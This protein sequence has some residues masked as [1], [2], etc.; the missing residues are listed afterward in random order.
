[1]GPDGRGANWT[2][3]ARLARQGR[4]GTVTVWNG[5]AG[6]ERCAMVGLGR[7]GLGR[8]VVEWTGVYRMGT[9][10]TRLER[11]VRRG[12]QGLGRTR[13]GRVRAGLAA[14]VH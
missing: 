14:L 12:M 6:G 10:W 11:Q 2:A 4:D 8:Q 1:M 3:R 5:P 9:E 7:K 13:R